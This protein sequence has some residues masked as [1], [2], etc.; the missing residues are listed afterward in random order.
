MSNYKHYKFN[1]SSYILINDGVV[2]ILKRH[3]IG[4]YFFFFT[5]GLLVSQVLNLITERLIFSSFGLI[6]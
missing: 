6:L 5:F 3:L 1:T 2:R 4:K